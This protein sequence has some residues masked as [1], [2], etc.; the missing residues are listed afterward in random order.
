MRS[1]DRQKIALWLFIVYSLSFICYIPSLL[2]Q[3][4]IPGAGGA[5]SLKHLFVCVPA[6]TSVLFLICE[7]DFKTCVAQMFSGKI[8]AQHIL[9]GI[10]Y[11]VVGMLVLI[12]IRS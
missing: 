4:G 5:L 7:H 12:A 6:I 2:E 11:V 9:K 8:T 10:V 1:A 3:H